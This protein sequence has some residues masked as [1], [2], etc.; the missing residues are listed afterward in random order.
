[1]SQ[2]NIAGDTSGS[3]AIAAPAVAGSNTL[4]LPASTGTVLTS[5]SPAS[6]LPSSIKG[7]AFSAYK[8][9][10]QTGISNATWTKVTFDVEDFDTNNN[11]T[12]S[13]FTPTVAGYYQINSTI[14]F[15]ATITN[16]TFCRVAIYKNGTLSKTTYISGSTL[17]RVIP[18]LSCLLYCNGT[19]DYLEV[20]GWLTGAN[21]GQFD[22]SSLTTFSASL[23]RSA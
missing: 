7:P 16:P 8:S 2:I 3:I 17:D 11:F 12:S 10:N 19:T 14:A 5:V 4:T 22:G 1:M 21:V 20:Y 23:I 13:A 9:A 15:N 18:S 6:D